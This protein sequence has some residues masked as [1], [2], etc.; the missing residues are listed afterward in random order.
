MRVTDPKQQV[1]DEFRN[2]VGWVTTLRDPLGHDDIYWY[3]RDG[4]VQRRTN[5]RGQAIDFDYDALHGLTWGGGTGVADAS[6]TYSPD[7]TVVTASNFY[8]TETQYLNAAGRPDSTLTRNFPPGGGYWDY[9]RRDTYTSA[10][11]LDSIWASGSSPAFLSRKYAYDPLRG[12]LDSIRLG[13][14]LT[15][16]NR[17]ADLLLGTI[18]L[19]GGD[20]VNR[21]FTSSHGDML[22]SSSA[23]YNS[24]VR[25]RIT[26]DAPGRLWR[27]LW[28]E[29]PPGWGGGH[30]YGYDGLGRLVADTLARTDNDSFCETPDPHLGI[31]CSGDFWTSW[32]V[33]STTSYGY[34]EVGNRT[35]AG[36]SYG[37]GNR[38]QALA[39]CSYA[40][41]LDGNVT[42]RSCGGTPPT[43]DIVWTADNRPS[44]FTVNGTVIDLYYDA[45]GRLARKDVNGAVASYFLWDGDHLFAELNGS[46]GNKRAEYSY[47]PGLDHL[48]ALA[49]E[50]VRYY[51]HYD[52]QGNVIALTGE[53]QAVK[54]TYQY[55]LFGEYDT[56]TDPGG[57]AGGGRGR[58]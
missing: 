24:S 47:Y 26:Y 36:G 33:S 57:L 30:L 54:R 53:D 28:D 41:D 37:P 32:W 7:G 21:S 38:I 17:N 27:Q 13:G 8:S 45:A 19:A 50:D 20:Q 39:G 25:R 35:D 44:R 43:L 12:T 46:D 31:T 49:V 10:G 48:H 4:L 5:R 58:G 34:D 40:T 1:Y 51:P 55:R 42:Q 14:A 29:Q 3:D 18:N 22:I 23:G 16:A 52:G 11:L 56:R 2:A 15:S 9:W 6:Y